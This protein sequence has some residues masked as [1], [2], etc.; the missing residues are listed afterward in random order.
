MEWLESYTSAGLNLHTLRLTNVFEVMRNSTLEII[1]RSL[2]VLELREFRGSAGFPKVFPCS[3]EFNPTASYSK[4]KYTTEHNPQCHGWTA[5]DFKMAAVITLKEIDS[6]SQGMEFETATRSRAA[7][8]MVHVSQRCQIITCNSFLQV[9]LVCSAE[10][11]TVMRVMRALF[12][13][14]NGAS[15]FSCFVENQSMAEFVFCVHRWK[16]TQVLSRHWC[17]AIMLCLTFRPGTIS[18]SLSME[19]NSFGN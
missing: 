1:L 5:L 12:C 13:V 16:L 10:K 11:F 18:H 8:A 14:C 17:M 9:R 3:E 19:Q 15:Q 6:N 4:P 2:R 7:L